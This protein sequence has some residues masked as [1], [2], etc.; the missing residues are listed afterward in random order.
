MSVKLWFYKSASP[1]VVKYEL[2]MVDKGVPLE[3]LDDGT[4]AGATVFDLGLPVADGNNKMWVEL[5]EL[6]GI[7]DK[8]GVFDF[9]VS[10]IDD[11][12]N[13]SSFLEIT[14]VSLDFVAPDAP[15]GGGIVRS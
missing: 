7:T 13:P 6:K 9:G 10:A 15:T 12:G 2:Y 4:V 8:D 3:R 5:E 11:A 1:D 14:N